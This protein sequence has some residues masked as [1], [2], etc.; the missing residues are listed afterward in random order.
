MN[1][2]YQDLVAH[3]WQ[4]DTEHNF[5]PN[6]IAIYFFILNVANSCFWKFPIGISNGITMM[7]FGIGK[8]AFDNA[9]K[10]L[11][12]AGIID[13]K[14]GDGRGNVYQYYIVI[15]GK[16]IS[17]EIKGIV[18]VYQKRTLYDTLSEIKKKKPKIPKKKSLA[19]PTEYWKELV[20]V[21]FTFYQKHHKGD[22][23][24]FDGPAR[25]G[26]EK[27]IGKLKKVNSEKSTTPWDLNRSVILMEHFLVKAWADPWRRNNFMLHILNSHFDAITQTDEN[28]R[29]NKNTGSGTDQINLSSAI[30]AISRLSN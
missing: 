1:V 13:F 19:E 4:K 14:P 30:A 24:T 28:E 17:Y 3:F 16:R 23:P 22:K 27:I 12:I 15:D 2:S 7:K 5:S 6:A 11:K 9:K 25:S 21:W 29:N 10:E 8:T 26:L 20:D 18:K